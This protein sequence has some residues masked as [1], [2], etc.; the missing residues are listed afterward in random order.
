MNSMTVPNRSWITTLLL[1]SLATV[2]LSGCKSSNPSPEQTTESATQKLRK[3]ISSD[4]AETGRREQM[5]KLVDKM[6]AVQT[7]FNK[8][9]VDFVTHYQT[10]NA[11]YDASRAAFDQ[12]FSQ[13][14]AERIQARGQALDLHFELA[15]LATD[16]EWGRI[17]E[18][19]AKMYDAIGIA[20]AKQEEIK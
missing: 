3:V 4:V 2:A 11:N 12:L 17:G 14:N 15:S 20:R 5:L 1:V 19:E 8:D 9:V 7:A 10:L 18:A 13:Y 6:E 16:K